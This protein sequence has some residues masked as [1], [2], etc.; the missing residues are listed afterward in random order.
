M[1]RNAEAWERRPPLPPTHYVD[2]R[3]Y[4]DETL[5]R[6]EREKI[7]SKTWIIACHE[8][9]LPGPYDFRTFQ[10]P[11]GP[12]LVLVRGD[13]GDVRA[14]FNI[15]PHRGNV[16][17]HEP[18]GTARA[19]TCIFHA[20]TFDCRG[21]CTGIAR[22]KEGYQD[23]LGTKDV[24][25]RAVRCQVGFGGFV[26][27]N[28]DDEGPSLGDF[29]GR[30]L[31]TLEPHISQPLEVFHY[32]K[33]AVNTNFKLWHDT[34]SEFYHDFMHYFNRV[35]GMQQ[36]GY[37]ERKY[38]PHPNGH[39]AVGSMEVKYDQYG[40]SG[41]RRI[42]WPGLAP[43]G[44]ILIDLFPGMTYNLRTS[45]IRLDV[46]IP[47]APNKTLIEIRGL[48]LRSDTA[49]E[50]AERVRDHNIIWGPF[51]RNLHEDLLG[52]AGQGSALRDGATGGRWLLHGREE[53][54]TIHDE[55]GMRHYYAEW[56]RRMGRLASSPFTDGG[57]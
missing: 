39:A 25:L 3:L 57:S 18:A 24:G 50:R 42:G 17:V 52:V 41:Q 53:N 15:C 13:D 46:V 28:L 7:F 51:G 12:N 40:G 22:R 30:A 56:S 26:W 19:L 14:F 37:F 33:I 36:P 49:E 10:H 47:I 45:V 2:S 21:G 1:S 38:V 31:A 32:Q 8:S 27:V 20:W 23:R 6:E 55:I 11:A 5:F 9:E 44:W 29:V 54:Q 35:T 43:G 34:N 16:L 4:T 48:G